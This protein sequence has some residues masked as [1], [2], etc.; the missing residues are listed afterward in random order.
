MKEN[1][2]DGY[3]SLYCFLFNKKHLSNDLF[4]VDDT[5]IWISAVEAISAV[6]T[7]DKVASLSKREGNDDKACVVGLA[8]IKDS[9]V[10]VNAT[11]MYMNP[12]IWNSYDALNDFCTVVKLYNYYVAPLNLSWLGTEQDLLVFKCW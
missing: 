5:Y 11:V 12:I 2:R 9:F 8:V 3:P 6:I 4:L 7:E 10:N 1:E